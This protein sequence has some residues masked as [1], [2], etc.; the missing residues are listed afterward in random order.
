MR[1]T[2]AK[3]C[4]PQK[5]HTHKKRTTANK[6]ADN[7]T[8]KQQKKTTQWSQ[9]AITLKT[10]VKFQQNRP[11]TIEI[12]CVSTDRSFYHPTHTH[13]QDKSSWR[14]VG[15][16]YYMEALTLSSTIHFRFPALTESQFILSF[17]SHNTQRA[18][19][20]LNKN[21]QSDSEAKES[22]I[23]L[24]IFQQKKDRE[25]WNKRPE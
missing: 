14:N 23:T 3:H 2:A 24:I 20:V 17:P 15:D 25:S 11:I 7:K 21:K 6:T 22:N 13:E 19:W 16:K 8:C 5:T 9:I 1:S 10:L 12:T 18:G 4:M